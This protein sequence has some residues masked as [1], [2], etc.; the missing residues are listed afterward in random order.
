MNFGTFHILLTIF[1][2]KAYAITQIIKFKL[3]FTFFVKLGRA[4]QSGRSKERRP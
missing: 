3:V 4:V 2:I 1:F